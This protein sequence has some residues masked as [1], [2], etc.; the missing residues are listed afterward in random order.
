[1]TYPTIHINFQSCSHS[2]DRFFKKKKIIMN[3]YSSLLLHHYLHL[4]HFLIMNKSSYF[5]KKKKNQLFINLSKKKKEGNFQKRPWDQGHWAR[6][7]QVALKKKKKIIN[8][9]FQ[10]LEKI[11]DFQIK[12]K[13]NLHLILLQEQKAM[14]IFHILQ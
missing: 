1:M 8:Q 10:F 6:T 4:L 5:K 11:Q 7:S 13:K 3:K 14:I 9:N 12:K 2:K